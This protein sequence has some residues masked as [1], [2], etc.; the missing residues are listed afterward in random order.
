MAGSDIEALFK[1]RAS[2]MVGLVLPISIFTNPNLSALESICRYLKDEKGLRYSEIA[3][4]LNRDQRTIWATYTNS[5]KKTKGRLDAP[6]SKYTI[7]LASF[8]DRSLSVLEAV[9]HHLKGRYSLR[10]S[11]IALLLGRDERNIWSIYR[12]AGR[13]LNA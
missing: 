12:K 7:P 2:G 1:E 6:D 8:K 11:E 9:V 5:L 10:Y 3:S 4:L 13:K